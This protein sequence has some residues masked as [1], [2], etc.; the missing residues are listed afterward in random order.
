MLMSTAWSATILFSRAFSFSSS[1]SRFV[2]GARIP[3]Y[4]ARSDGT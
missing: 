3:P 4:R 1:R 2:S